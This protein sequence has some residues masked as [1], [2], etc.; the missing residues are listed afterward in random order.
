MRVAARHNAFVLPPIERRSGRSDLSLRAEAF[1]D[2]FEFSVGHMMKTIKVAILL[3]TGLFV[4]GLA[5]ALRPL[6]Q[7]GI[8][9][10]LA[11]MF[12]CLGALLV[13]TGTASQITTTPKQ[14]QNR[15]FDE[16]GWA[17]VEPFGWLSLGLVILAGGYSVF[18]GVAVFLSCLLFAALM[19]RRFG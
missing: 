10:G 3:A 8:W 16:I 4:L 18:L 15:F 14:S 1:R 19:F 17:F 11:V 13:G 6:M 5:V 12:I 7:G 2:A 9:P